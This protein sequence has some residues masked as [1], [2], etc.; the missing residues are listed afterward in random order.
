MAAI[1]K[2]KYTVDEKVF[3]IPLKGEL[4]FEERLV[5]VVN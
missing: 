1:A 2:R 4:F 5:V 3:S